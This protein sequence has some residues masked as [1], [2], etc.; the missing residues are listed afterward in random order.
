M[1]VHWRRAGY[2][3]A[4]GCLTT[5][6]M[7]LTALTA[8]QCGLFELGRYRPGPDLLGRWIG[9]MAEGRFMHSCIL[10]S[11][12]VPGEV[13]L[14]IVCHYL[15]GVT[16]A[17]IFVCLRLA[18]LRKGIGLASAVAYGLAT[19]IFP[20]FLMFPAMGF[21][22]MGLN[23]SHE[24]MLPAFSA[25]NHLTF[26]VWI[27]VWGNLFRKGLTGRQPIAPQTGTSVSPNRTL[28]GSRDG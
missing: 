16:L 12:P 20:W 26:G 4:T 17:S 5:I 15:I 1:K 28:V 21:G 18:F 13:G 7:D 25:F 14:G 22:V 11:S 8:V 19:C 23:V 10:D 6:S 27:C 24:S 3:L 9:S 2:F